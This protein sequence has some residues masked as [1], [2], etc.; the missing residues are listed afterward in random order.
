MEDVLAAFETSD[1]AASKRQLRGPET[2]PLVAPADGFLPRKE[3]NN[4]TPAVFLLHQTKPKKT[5]IESHNERKEHVLE[6]T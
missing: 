4:K 3:Q 2:K 6:A 5:N 1:H